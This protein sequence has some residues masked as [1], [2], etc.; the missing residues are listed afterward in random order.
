MCRGTP[1]F[2]TLSI[3]WSGSVSAQSV[4]VLSTTSTLSSGTRAERAAQ[5]SGATRWADSVRRI[6]DAAV[7]RG[8]VVATKLGVTLADRALA[9]FPTDGLLLHYRGYAVYRL[10][11]LAA[12]NA[13]AGDSKALYEESLEWLDRSHAL[14]PMAETH[15]L[16]ASAMGQLMA[17]SMLLGVRYGATSNRADSDADRLSPN[18]PRVLLLRAIA[19][20]F[21]PTMFGGGEDKARVIM[22]R[23]LAAF[24]TDA[25]SGALPA[26]GHAEALVWHGQMEQKAGRIA[27]ARAAFEHALVL[28][29]E[30]GWAKQLLRQNAP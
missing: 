20:W 4:G 5:L 26:W 18:N 2:I 10:A 3:L 23:A 19:T 1:L 29:P 13:A 12:R 14:R 7:I 30:Y 24:D 27:S 16:R 28:E 25:P 17:K 15:A 21:K 22:T 9:A 8:D 6:V 11:Q